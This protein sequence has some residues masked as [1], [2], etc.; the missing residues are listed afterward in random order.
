MEISVCAFMDAWCVVGVKEHKPG[1]PVMRTTDRGGE[2][3]AEASET[4]T[5]RI[6][7]VSEKLSDF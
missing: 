6:F 7:N 4:P 1:D 2:D 3:I 5:V